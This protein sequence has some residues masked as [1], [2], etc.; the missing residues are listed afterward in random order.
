MCG[1]LPWSVSDQG[2]L[3]TPL[4]NTELLTEHLLLS[5]RRAGQRIRFCYDE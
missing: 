5:A 1:N 2:A 4:K 3:L